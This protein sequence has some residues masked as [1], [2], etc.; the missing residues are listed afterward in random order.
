[1]NQPLPLP[2]IK[3]APKDFGDGWMT[4]N[5]QELAKIAITFGGFDAQEL[6]YAITKLQKS[7][8][9]TAVNVTTVSNALQLI[10]DTHAAAQPELYAADKKKKAQA[11]ARLGL[12]APQA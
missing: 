4:K 3:L 12:S 7:K 8:G 5:A 11:Y 10:Y 6:I 2:D 9:K 1:V